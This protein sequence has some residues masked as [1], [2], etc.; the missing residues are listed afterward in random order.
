MM[1]FFY[2]FKRIIEVMEP[3]IFT[4]IINGEIP[5][6]KVYEDEFV[7]AIMDIHPIQPGMVV[8]IVKQQI[9]KLEDLPSDQYLGVWA[10]AHKITKALR[11]AFPQKDRVAIKVEGLD[12]SH[13]HV[14]AFPFSTEEELTAKQNQDEPNHEELEEQAELI[15]GEI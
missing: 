8:I 4:K 6:H 5:S 3:S 1:Y 9:E 11:R 7:F 15:K 13:A 10:A 2:F 12:V 14:V